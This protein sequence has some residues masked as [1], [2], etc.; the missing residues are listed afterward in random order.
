MLRLLHTS[1]WHL[2]QS[3][4]DLDRSEEHLAFLSWLGDL[5]EREFQ[6]GNPFH[7]TLIA[8]DVFDNP[9]PSARA[10]GLFYEFLERA[11]HFTQ[12]VVIAGNHDSAERLQAPSPLFS[13]LGIHIIGHW[14]EDNQPAELVIPVQGDRESALILA[15]PFLRLGDL[16]SFQAG[17]A[18]DHF[19]QAHKKRYQQLLETAQAHPQF[20]KN[21]QTTLIGMGHCFVSGAATNEETERRVGLQDELPLEVFPL[22]LAYLALGHLHR[23]QRVGKHE[24]MHYCGSP[25]PLGFS[26]AGYAHQILDVCLQGGICASVTPVP[27][28]A[29]RPWLRVP[30]QHASWADVLQQIDQLEPLSGRSANDPLRPLLEVRLLPGLD[31]P[32]DLRERLQERLADK[33]PLF[34]RIDVFQASARNHIAEAPQEDLLALEDLSPLEVFRSLCAEEHIEAQGR[35]ELEKDF[36]SLLEEWRTEGNP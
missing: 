14:P 17:Q 26:E 3:L 32:T 12:L 33:W 36:Q 8:G 7:A 4:R 10:Q 29:F 21:E 35:A 13:R 9:N 31:V 18:A 11:R 2:G 5:L 22:N 27:V 20:Q 19:A 16:G 15:M 28:P 23:P 1:D 25:L 24:F 6:A 30:V 34:F